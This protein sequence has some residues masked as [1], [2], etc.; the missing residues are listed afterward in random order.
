MGLRYGKYIILLWC[1]IS[2]PWRN[3]VN[4]CLCQKKEK[5]YPKRG[6]RNQWDGG[7]NFGKHLV[8]W[9]RLNKNGGKRSVRISIHGYL[10]VVIL[11]LVISRE[12][13]VLNSPNGFWRSL[14]KT[15][16][17]S[18][19]ANLKTWLP[20]NP[21]PSLCIC[22]AECLASSSQTFQQFIRPMFL[23]SYTS[24]TKTDCI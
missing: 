16:F 24:K 7:L 23:L 9:E 5:P 10:W 19:S 18:S 15:H 21:C 13:T 4:L 22:K 6:F 20:I 12:F 8:F 2:I 14:S 1:P 3:F 11:Y 17:F